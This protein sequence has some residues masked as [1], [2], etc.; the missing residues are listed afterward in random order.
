M[1]KS[2]QEH[3]AIR[4]LYEKKYELDKQF[5]FRWPRLKEDIE[6]Y[7][8][9]LMNTVEQAVDMANHP[10]IIGHTGLVYIPESKKKKVPSEEGEI[11]E[12]SAEAD[13]EEEEEEDLDSLIEGEAMYSADTVRKSKRKSKKKK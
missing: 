1:T 12:D 9:I 2:K 10:R 5:G 6:A 7:A 3:N 13:D 11:T 4:F 8:N